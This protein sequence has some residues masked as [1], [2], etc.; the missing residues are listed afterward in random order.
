M[1]KMKCLFSLFVLLITVSLFAERA[2]AQGAFQPFGV[3][4]ENLDVSKCNPNIGCPLIDQAAN[5]GAQ[6]MRLLAIWWFLE[7]QQ[8]QF[9]WGI[10]P[11]Q[12]WYAQQR[13][14]NVYFTATW[15]PQWANGAASTT[16]PYAGGNCG[17]CGR[18]VLNSNYTYTFF[19]NLASQ[20]NGSTTASCASGDPTN[21][22]PLVQYFGVWNEPNNANNYNDVYFDPNN[23][24]NYL[25]DFVNQYLFPAY[26]GVKQANPSAFVVA[27]DLQQGNVS[28][29]NFS[30]YNGCNY[31]S[32]WLQP[33]MQYFSS[34][35]DII[36]V[37][38]HQSTHDDT[39]NEIDNEVVA[40][41]GASK[42]I[43]VTECDFSS[44]EASNV[45]TVYVDEFNRSSYWTKI[46]YNLAGYSPCGQ[47]G[48]LCSNDG[49]NLTDTSAFFAY[50]QVYAPH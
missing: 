35:F 49:V 5:A 46:F 10:L 20:F 28:C 42:F 8:N 13:G 24:G 40:N 14:I 47:K 19:Y 4:A 18:T 29:G 7:P 15:A 22:H 39:K 25:S 43:W 12:V 50:Q 30:V 23:P 11:W 31:I 36:S 45:T 17:D 6:W 16:P 27:P 41:V 32:S 2:N 38:S 3:D 48:L 1:M 44:S 33:L 34:S 37:H 9:N 21:C 26:N